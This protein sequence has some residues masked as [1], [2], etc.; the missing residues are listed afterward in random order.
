M[1]NHIH[2]LGASGSGTTTLGMEL[3]KKMGYYHFD[4]DD[5]YWEQTDIPY[6]KT[7][8]G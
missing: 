2:I 4:T 7:K 1:K 8:S 6:T 5:F 3:A